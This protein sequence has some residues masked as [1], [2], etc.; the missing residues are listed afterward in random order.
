MKIWQH[1]AKR[2]KSALPKVFALLRA[3]SA[4]FIFQEAENSDNLSFIRV[5][6]ILGNAQNLKLA[7]EIL[8]CFL[9]TLTLS[10]TVIYEM[11]PNCISKCPQMRKKRFWGQFWGTSSWK[12]RPLK[13][14]FGSS[15]ERPKIHR[16]NNN[17]ISA[18]LECRGSSSSM[19][20]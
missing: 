3:S 2:A 11:P 13:N 18:D 4:N 17:D 1:W 16:N 20:K 5:R 19:Y 14:A 12:S 9:T 6:N 7:M 8:V 15:K 10:R